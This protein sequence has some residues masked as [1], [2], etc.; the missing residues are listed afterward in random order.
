MKLLLSAF[1]CEPGKG[2]EEGVGWGIAWNLA[3]THRVHVLTTPRHRTAIEQFHVRSPQPNLTFSYLDFSPWIVARVVTSA[4]W[5][6]YYYAW[7]SR[8]GTW[9]QPVVEAFDPDLIHH[10]TY[11]RYWTP[12]SLWRLKRP[13]IWGPLGG[14]DFCPPAFLSCLSFKEKVGEKL[15]QI[16]QRLAHCD[17]QLRLTAENSSVALSS[18][19]WTSNRLKALGC[20]R[21][22]PLLQMAVDADLLESSRPAANEE[23]LFCSVGRLLGWKG[24]T[25]TLQAFA[26]ASIPRARLVIIGTG[27][28]QKRL[29]A[30]AGAL[31]IAD[32]VSFLGATTRRQTF[33]YIQRSVALVHPSLHDQAPTVVFEAMAAG[34]PVIALA[35]A[36]LP[37]QLTAETGFL[38]PA[39]SHEQA[40]TAIA[41]A[42]RELSNDPDLRA[43]MGAAGRQRI[44]DYFTWEKKAEQLDDIYQ[45]L[46]GVPEQT[47]V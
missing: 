5:Q 31:G 43:R 28:A 20:R 47:R 30:L 33:E 17:P 4:L 27:P 34:T 37:L 25:L 6:V 40:V 46:L 41:R 3:K 42:M 8:V 45:S 15:R 29:V 18:T 2:S 23:I 32:R 21:T 13:F 19:P 9:A 10:V 12:N 36:G 1:A 35:L 38:I 14:G 11:G 24:Q 16:A 44:A 39:Q 26:E 7:Q 22:V